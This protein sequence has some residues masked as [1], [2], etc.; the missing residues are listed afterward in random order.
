M[1]QKT[2]CEFVTSGCDASNDDKD[3]CTSSAPCA[4]G[5]GD[6]DND[7]Q[8]AGDLVCGTDNCIDFDTAWPDSAFDCCT[9]GNKSY[10][11]RLGM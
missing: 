7:S 9:T 11:C 8:C 1:F 3:C 2:F 5:E 10:K 6:C 4:M